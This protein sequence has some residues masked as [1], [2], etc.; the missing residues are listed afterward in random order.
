MY[1]GQSQLLNIYDTMYYTCIHCCFFVQINM[2][3]ILG[4][5]CE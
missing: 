1:I 2:S 3:A 5:H 4:L